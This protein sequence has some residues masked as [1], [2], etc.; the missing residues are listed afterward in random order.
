[1][2]VFS[3]EMTGTNSFILILAQCQDWRSASSVFDPGEVSEV[4]AGVEL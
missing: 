3:D 4:G 1:M 2:K